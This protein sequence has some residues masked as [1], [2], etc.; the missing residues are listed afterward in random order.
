MITDVYLNAKL[1]TAPLSYAL[2]DK[3]RHPERRKKLEKK[4]F[5]SR[6]ALN[7]RSTLH[8]STLTARLCVKHSHPGHLLPNVARMHHCDALGERPGHATRPG[9]HVRTGGRIGVTLATGMCRMA[10]D[11]PESP[12]VVE[13]RAG[14]AL[15]E[16][17]PAGSLTGVAGLRAAGRRAF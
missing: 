7:A 12:L 11:A 4:K 17:L 1:Y 8:I 3:R 9:G 14:S 15:P 5:R 2:L 13:A 16:A 10:S 6:S